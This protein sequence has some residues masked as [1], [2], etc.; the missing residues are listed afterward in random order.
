MKTTAYKGSIF[1][2]LFMLVFIT[3]SILFVLGY[4]FFIYKFT[5]NEMIQNKKLSIII[6]KTLSQDLAKLILLDNVSSAADI[7]AKLKSFDKIISVVVFDKK[8][9]PIYQYSKNKKSFRVNMIPKTIGYQAK[10][11]IFN[12][13]VEAIY[14]GRKLGMINMKIKRKTIIQILN[15]NMNFIILSYIFILFISYLLAYLYAKYFTKPIIKL[16][17][18]LDTIEWTASLKKRISTNEDNEFGKL[19][20]EVNIMLSKLESAYEEQKIATVAF[21]TQ[22]GIIIAD[23]GDKILQVNSAFSKITGYKKEE[24]IGKNTSVLRSDLHNDD[25]YDYINNRVRQ[26][27]FY[28]GEIFFRDKHKNMKNLSLTIQPVFNDKNQIRYLV[29]SFLDITQQKETE[30]ELKYLQSYDPLTGLANRS[31]FINTLQSRINI[32]HA[33]KRWHTLLCIDINDFKSIN[34]IYGH[35]VG[36]WILRELAQR[37]KEE[38][39]DSDF[40]GKIGIDEYIISKRNI[41]DTKDEAFGNS[42]KL[43]ERLNNIVIHTFNI[44]HIVVNISI[45]IGINVYNHLEKDAKIILKRADSALQTAKKEDKKVAFF[46]KDMESKS[47]K[48]FKTYNELLIALKEKQFEL[49]YQLQYKDDKSI[50]GAEAL[51]RWNHPQK[52]VIS[53]V[54]FIG[55]AENKDIIIDIG[56]WV[57][58]EG[59]K[60]LSLWQKDEKTK[61][62][63]LA[64]NV[65][66]KQFYQDNFVKKVIDKVKKYN[67][68]PSKLKL[69]LTESLIVNDF[70][71]VIS[72]M[73]QLRKYGIQISIDDF[74]TGYS[75]LQYLKNFPADQIK[76]DQTFILNLTKSK[77]DAAIVKSI[78]ELGTAL[79]FEV[80]AEGVKSKEHFELLKELGCKYYQGYYFAKPVKSIQILQ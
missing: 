21:E 19:Y 70:K 41:G 31:L 8:G 48:Y 69:E 15:N 63:V 65:S 40:I 66:T 36:D 34:D 79:G 18:F 7:T 25:F 72:K 43:I 11:D 20:E 57:I 3:T 71:N 49:Y 38:F 35:E 67:I 32:N 4:I 51:I 58:D 22:N 78:I 16:V 77:N 27:H 6:E 23:I 52:G 56:D 55:I 39:K 14:M 60:Q 76:I 26:E 2:K 5:Q 50:Y 68:V 62:L 47:L 75:S 54:D 73:K 45:K 59:C 53:P 61:E 17:H 24:V 37:L 29:Y 30:A 80:I 74:G 12:V 9:T 13:N 64:V 10:G 1:K 33:R 28:S 46:D 44:N 42:E